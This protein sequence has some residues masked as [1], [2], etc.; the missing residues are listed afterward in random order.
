MAIS[1]ELKGREKA[2]FKESTSVSGQAAVVVVNPDG[3]DIGAS[4]SAAGILADDSAFTVAS[5]KVQNIGLLADETATDSVDE[6]DV[7]IPRMT[8][9]RRQITASEN[10]DDVAWTT[11]NKVSVIGGVYDDVSTD[12]VDEGDVGYIRIDA[13]RNAR[14]SLGTLLSGEDQTNALLSVATKPVAVSTYSPDMDTSAAAEASS[15]TKA[16]AGVLYGVT[17]SNAN[18]STRY[19]QFFNSTTVPADSTVPVITIACHAGSTVAVEWPKGRYF[20]TGIAWCNSSTQNTKTVGSAD[21]LADVHY[22]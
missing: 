20:S 1:G 11:A 16:S 8:L 12:V 21:S 13:N 3:S 19:L 15:V 22:K 18:A 4:G 5:S 9:D 2:K 17:F 10:T 6:G 7:G 14:V